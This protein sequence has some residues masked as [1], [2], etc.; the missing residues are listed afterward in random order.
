MSN[1]IQPVIGQGAI[2]MSGGPKTSKGKAVAKLNATT[3]GMRAAMPVIPGEDVAVWEGH[4]AAIVDALV[5]VG[6]MEDAL[7]ERI[8][9]LMWRLE[10]VS[11]YETAMLAGSVADTERDYAY[12]EEQKQRYPNSCV[13]T[14]IPNTPEE[15][16][17][18]IRDATATARLLR[19]L[20]TR[21]GEE[22]V[23]G[24]TVGLILNEAGKSAMEAT[25]DEDFDPDETA[26]SGLPHGS[27]W[28]DLTY[29]SVATIREC[30][31]ALAAAAKTDA[32][33]L[34]TGVAYHYECE[35]RSARFRLEVVERE[36]SRMEAERLM[37]PPLVLDKVTRY[38]AH[39]H[40]QL[41]QTM[42]ELEA[43]QERQRGH[44]APLARLDVSGLGRV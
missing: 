27:D 40:R 18:A 7:A 42:H 22:R 16:R 38:E 5:P 13:Y 33:R 39:L 25:A 3:H 2:T 9:L 36:L 24:V 28:D 31:A 44:A 10:R 19:R 17:D 4:R 35:A 14:Y 37:L 21:R 23:A 34:V 29:V 6:A 20:D 32:A 26:Y 12:N 30:F 8:A 15:C 41:V 11:R 43:M 1:M